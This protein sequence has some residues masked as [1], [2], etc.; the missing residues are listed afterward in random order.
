LILTASPDP[1]VAVAV[2]AATRALAVI[3]AGKFSSPGC[4]VFRPKSR[5]NGAKNTEN[6]A[7]NTENGAKNTENGAENTENGAKIAEIGAKIAEIELENGNAKSGSGWV[8]VPDAP[9]VV[10]ESFF[11]FFFHTHN[12]QIIHWVA[13]WNH[14][15]KYGVVLKK[16]WK[17]LISSN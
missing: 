11:F 8:A 12:M 4:F 14:S 13:F 6:G 15:Q 3:S 5:E 7:K 1:A 9:P 17:V 16:K 2:A 10:R